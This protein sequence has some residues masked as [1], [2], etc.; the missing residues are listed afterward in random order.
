LI[1][2]DYKFTNQYGLRWDATNETAY[3]STFLIDRRDIIFYRKVSQGHGDRTTAS[4][5]LKVLL[6][7]NNARRSNVLG[8]V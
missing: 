2:S 1:D 7:A 3:P 8:G 6:N 4:D 5:V